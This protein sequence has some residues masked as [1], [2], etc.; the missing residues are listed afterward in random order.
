M[1][2]L[3][4][5]ACEKAGLHYAKRHWYE[6]DVPGARG[7]HEQNAA[8]LPFVAERLREPLDDLPPG[9]WDLYDIRLEELFGLL[10]ERAP[11][12]HRIAAAMVALGEWQMDEARAFIA[13]QEVVW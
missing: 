8:L 3:L 7:L 9:P 4:Q 5:Q 6:S 2:T 12:R 1:S 10:T 13:E 11:A